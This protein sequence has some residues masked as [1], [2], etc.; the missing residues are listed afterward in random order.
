MP[1]YNEPP[2]AREQE[3]WS[4]DDAPDVRRGDKVYENGEILVTV[5]SV[6][7]NGTPDHSEPW[8]KI[9]R[10][11]ATGGVVFACVPLNTLSAHDSVT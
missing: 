8:A 2:T 6:H 3:D 7:P 1:R 9:M 11:P 10:A 4:P 5:V